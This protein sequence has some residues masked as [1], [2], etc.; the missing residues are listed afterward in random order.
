M[1]GW[2]QQLYWGTHGADN[3]LVLG[4]PLNTA[5]LSVW[6]LLQAGF[7]VVPT[8]GGLRSASAPAA[9]FEGAQY[10]MTYFGAG[11]CIEVAGG[12]ALFCGN[13][14]AVPPA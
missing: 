9:S 7:G 14:S 5:L 12:R 13:G 2:A 10:N 4:D 6:G 1:R 8:L 3:T 11:M